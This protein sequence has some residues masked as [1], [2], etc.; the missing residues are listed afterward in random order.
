MKISIIGI[1]SVGSAIATAVK[2]TGIAHEIVLFDID[3]I[4]ARAAAEDLGHAAAFSF[5]VKITAANNYRALRGS[6][7][8]I[9]SAG[10]NQKPGETRMDLLNKN[11]A[12]IR[13]VVPKIMANVE[14]KNVKLVIVTNPLDVMV[15]LAQKLSRLPSARVIGTGTMLDSAR[16]RVILSRRLS[17]SPQSVNAYVLGE[18]GDSSVIAWQSA[19]I[20]AIALD[21]F[22]NQINVPLTKST[23][24]T[25]EHR[26]HN[27]AYEIIRGRGATWDGIA[28]AVA[29]LIRSIANDENRILTV[30][31]VMG[32]GKD[33]VALSLPCIVG[34]SG[35]TK[36]LIPQMNGAESSDLQRSAKIIRKNY[37][38]IMK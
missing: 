10:A 2:N 34:T 4:R 22:C 37:D 26:V 1:G 24:A 25:I 19:S 14:N 16:L 5:D 3:G 32:S 21:D 12:V 11:A 27:A 31:T 30:S 13:D 18:H 20:G 7:I 33:S 9:I 8:V 23:R 36:T 6:E 38:K 28:G 15:M 29:D 35:A 17:V